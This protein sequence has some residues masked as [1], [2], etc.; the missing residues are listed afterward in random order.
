MVVVA[1][2]VV[3]VAVV[4]GNCLAF[5]CSVCRRQFVWL[6]A[7]EETVGMW[8]GKHGAGQ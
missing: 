6:V 5:I 3:A 8:N 7:D 1:A 4:V 2:A